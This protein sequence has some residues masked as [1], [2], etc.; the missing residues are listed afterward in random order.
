MLMHAWIF[1]H[2][3]GVLPMD[4]SNSYIEDHPPHTH[5]HSHAML[6]VSVKGLVVIDPYNAH[7]DHMGVWKNEWIKKNRG[8]KTS[9]MVFCYWTQAERDLT[10]IGLQ[11]TWVKSCWHIISMS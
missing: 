8:K 3:N 1:Q 5:T 4:Y 2:F 6:F 7:M 10:H 11:P 9:T